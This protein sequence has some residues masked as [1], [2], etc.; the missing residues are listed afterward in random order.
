MPTVPTMRSP[1][2]PALA[3][4]LSAL[5]PGFGQLYNRQWAKGAGFLIAMII[6]DAALGVSRDMLA[7]FQSLF[8]GTPPP[9]AGSLALR[10]L[11]VLGIA[12]WSIQDAIHT[13]KQTASA[14]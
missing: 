6:T 1:R 13:A 4:L 2:H 14:H 10:S 7:V 9:S 12:L 5:V 11:P 3:G 8:A